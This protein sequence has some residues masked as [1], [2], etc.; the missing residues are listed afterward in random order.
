MKTRTINFIFFVL[1]FLGIVGCNNDKIFTGI[2]GTIK[3]GHGDCM[4]IVGG[5]PVRTFTN[6]NGKIFFIVKDDFDHFGRGE[7]E[8][9]K[10]NSISVNIDNGKLSA[11]LPV[12]TYVIEPEDF[13]VYPEENIITI[14]SGQ[15]IQ[16]DF[17]FFE[18]TSY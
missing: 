2:T 5:N 12:G 7:Y 13:Y 6:Y 18:C 10:H 16:K 8:K 1:C 9:L 15:I 4:P 3:Y 14:Q 17:K 11:E